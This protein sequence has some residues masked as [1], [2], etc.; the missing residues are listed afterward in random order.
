MPNCYQTPGSFQAGSQSL[1]GNTNG[2]YTSVNSDKLLAD[3]GLTNARLIVA[4]NI[5]DVAYNQ[6]LLTI[7]EVL[8]VASQT[9]LDYERN[10][11]IHGVILKTKE[12]A[13]P[14]LENLERLKLVGQL[15]AT[16][17]LTAKQTFSNLELAETE[18]LLRLAVVSD[19]LLDIF[20][21]EAEKLNVKSSDIANSISDNNI[22][23]SD[24]YYVLNTLNLRKGFTAYCIRRVRI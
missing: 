21:A 5:I 10:R 24:K 14:L 20:G 6:Y 19:S 16:K 9:Y 1:R 2:L 7:D 12:V 11:K 3:G 23:F 18:V 8:L 22:L 4:N 13:I 17:V 15:D